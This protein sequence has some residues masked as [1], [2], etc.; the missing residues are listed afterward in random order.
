MQIP[1]GEIFVTFWMRYEWKLRNF[2]AT[3]SIE[4]N[5]YNLE[6]AQKTFQN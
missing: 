2:M 1:P 6:N 3:S 4:K 5:M